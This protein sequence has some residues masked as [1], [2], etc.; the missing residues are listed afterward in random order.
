MKCPIHNLEM[1][2]GGETPFG[3]DFWI[4]E[5]CEAMFEEAA[6]TCPECGKL[7]EF[8]ECYVFIDDDEHKEYLQ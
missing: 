1:E 3:Q 4:C 6:Q 8:C 2:Y 7:A 5:E